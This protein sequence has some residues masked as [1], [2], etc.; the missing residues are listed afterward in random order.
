[1]DMP[2]RVDG[3]TTGARKQNGQIQIIVGVAVTERTTVE[4]HRVVQEVSVGFLDRSQFIEEVRQMCH[5]MVI[6]ATELGLRFLAANVMRQIMVP[7]R[8]TELREAAIVATVSDHQG[9]RSRRVGLKCQHGHVHH[10]T[11]TII[12]VSGDSDQSRVKPV[13][14]RFLPVFGTLNPPLDLANGIK[15]FVQLASIV[16]PQPALQR[17]GVLDDEVPGY[18]FFHD[19]VATGLRFPPS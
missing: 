12:R 1:M 6:D 5:V 7:F 10:Q 18:S 15:V 4:D 19:A 3:T 8:N 13:Q 9:N 2:T 17:L 11:E 14:P 16:D